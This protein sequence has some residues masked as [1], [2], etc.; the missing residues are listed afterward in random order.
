MLNWIYPGPSLDFVT[1]FPSINPDRQR[2]FSGGDAVS[3]LKEFLDHVFMGKFLGPFPR[4]VKTLCGLPIRLITTFII[5]KSDSTVTL[6]KNR[7][8]INC[9]EEHKD[10]KSFQPHPDDPTFAFW[11]G[12]KAVKTFN[13]ALIKFSC[14]FTKT[15]TIIKGLY[16]CKLIWKAD[17]WKGFRVFVRA[18][19]SW[20]DTGV[21][22]RV[23]HPV[24]KELWEA[25]FL[26]ITIPMGVSTSPCIFSLVLSMFTRG[27]IFHFPDLFGG[28]EALD[29]LFSFID[30]FMGGAHSHEHAMQQIA[31]LKLFGEMLGLKF[32]N[33]KMEWPKSE[34]CLLGL[35]LN[36]LFSSVYL[37][38]G[39]NEKF[40]S[41]VRQL[42]SSKVWKTKDVQSLCGNLIW[43]SLIIPK[44]CAF[45]N[46]FIMLQSHFSGSVVLRPTR[47]PGL[48]RECV[49]ALEF[50]LP[51][52]EIDPAVHIKKFLGQLKPLRIL[53][54]S[55]ASGWE[56][57]APWMK[58]D[59]PTQGQLACVFLS[60]KTH[61]VFAVRWKDLIRKVVFDAWDQ[62]LFALD[63]A[64]PQY[65]P[66]LSEP[67]IAFLEFSSLILNVIQIYHL[68][69]RDQGNLF[70]RKWIKLAT[71]NQNTETWV[72]KGRCPFF[73]FSRLS[74]FV[75]VVELLLESSF[76]AVYVPSEKQLA[77]PLTRGAS[78]ITF[79]PTK[80]IGSSH[81]RK[82]KP[83]RWKCK[84]PSEF[85]I[86]LFCAILSN[87]KTPAELFG[88][89]AR[90]LTAP[91]GRLSRTVTKPNPH[92]NRTV[93]L[94]CE[95]HLLPASRPKVE[96]STF[97]RCDNL[98]LDCLF[99]C[100]RESQGVPQNTF[101]HLQ[102]SRGP[103]NFTKP[104]PDQ[105][106]RR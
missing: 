67:S 16:T 92:T 95:A 20:A 66:S 59:N 56:T 53:P 83:I 79:V 25:I 9:S 40:A 2:C 22:L 27:M 14:S 50:I 12:K 71:D 77:D 73:P 6:Q 10:F 48:H 72:N 60:L 51:I 69:L 82:A 41:L 11:C 44:M 54:Y 86:S 87:K 106:G 4:W 31:V 90:T 1:D 23:F 47:L 15:K 52:V 93:H 65:D 100:F 84:K 96:G 38:M 89:K 17:L 103:V 81:K 8:L 76:T 45:A 32:L 61:W 29:L 97:L 13:E 99:F 105:F 57:D 91:R 18:K 24:T 30:D 80:S 21:L 75:V 39:K 35:T 43:L 58:A 19:A 94:G 36:V 26:D 104:A 88:D 98:G 70:A 101:Y 68:F 7:V 37:K 5:G 42:L 74:E 33:S 85:V 64:R 55:D 46:P 102:S 34:Q 49:R 3:V 62:R 63:R 28:E 78:H